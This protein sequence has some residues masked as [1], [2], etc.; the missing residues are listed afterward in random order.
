MNYDGEFIIMKKLSKCAITRLFALFLL[1]FLTSFNPIT[2]TPTS[3]ASL[4]AIYKLQVPVKK[5]YFVFFDLGDVLLSVSKASFFGNNKVVLLKYI[6]KHGIPNGDQLKKRLFELMDYRTNLPRGTATSGKEQMPQ[7]M[8]DWLCGKVSSEHFVT[9]ITNIEPTDDFFA[10]EAEGNVIINMAKLM[11]PE[12]L[13]NTH[14]TTNMLSVFNNCCEQDSSRVCILSNWDKSSIGN[15][16]AKFPQIFSKIKDEQ[17]LFSGELGCHK[18]DGEIYNL[19][20]KRIG[21]VANQCILIDDQ[22]ANIDAANECGWH[23]ILHR[24]KKETAQ[25]LNEQYE[26]ACNI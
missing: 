26:F 12:L 16:K 9:T 14:Q 18:P 24:N 13:V 5:G 8:C 17:I 7:I 21:L 10:S 11:L 20:A 22:I 6:L 25:I 23:G 19:A 4:S 15:L 3:L 1:I 2:S